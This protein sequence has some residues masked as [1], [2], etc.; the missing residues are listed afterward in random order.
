MTTQEQ[1][2]AHVARKDKMPPAEY[3]A[4]G[5]ALMAGYVYQAPWR[6]IIRFWLFIFLVVGLAVFVIGLYFN[7][8]LGPRLLPTDSPNITYG[9]WTP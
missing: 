1:W 3:E 8:T 6:Y 2:N 9:T 5:N 7:A 4:E